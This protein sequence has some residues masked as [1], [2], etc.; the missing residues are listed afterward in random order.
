MHAQ[1]FM[2]PQVANVR[3][4]PP[5]PPRPSLG[6]RNYVPNPPAVYMQSSLFLGLAAEGWLGSLLVHCC[7][8]CPPRVSAK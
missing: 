2:L 8:E 3:G 7:A 6:M 5:A 4:A 1:N